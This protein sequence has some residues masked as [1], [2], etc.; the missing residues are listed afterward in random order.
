AAR[1]CRRFP[2]AFALVA[3]GKLH[4]SALCSLKPHLEPD[5]AGELFELCS[6][7]SARRID[8]LLAARFPKPDVRDAIRRLPSRRAPGAVA[9]VGLETRTSDAGSIGAGMRAPTAAQRPTEIT[10]ATSGSAAPA[11]MEQRNGRPPAVA[12]MPPQASSAPARLEPLSA[13]RFAV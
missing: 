10:P 2:E 5:N 1:V 8:E 7:Q 9:G 11:A 13:D 6:N 4:L 3:S 12:K